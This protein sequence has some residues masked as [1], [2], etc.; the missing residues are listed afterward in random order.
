MG[1]LSGGFQPVL[2]DLDIDGVRRG[3]GVVG[4]DVLLLKADPVQPLRRQAV[5]AVGAL[6]GVGEGAQHALDHAALAADVMRRTDVTRRVER[7][8]ADPLAGP[9]RG[10]HDGFSARAATSASFFPNSSA[11]TTPRRSNALLIDVI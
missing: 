4:P 2:E 10:A 1:I 7:L 6:L 5:A 3:P 9:E 11:V 8:D